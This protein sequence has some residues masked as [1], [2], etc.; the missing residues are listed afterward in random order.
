MRFLFFVRVIQ[1]SEVL[2]F[3]IFSRS[4]I[5]RPFSAMLKFVTNDS[6]SVCCSTHSVV[7]FSNNGN[8]RRRIAFRGGDGPFLKKKVQINQSINQFRQWE[9]TLAIFVGKISEHFLSGRI[10]RSILF[11]SAHRSITRFTFR[12]VWIIKQSIER[13]D[14][15]ATL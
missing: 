11:H 5:S 7:S 6:L 14:V 13:N 3:G 8:I 2:G 9:L 1:P 15:V 12:G 10:S 4:A